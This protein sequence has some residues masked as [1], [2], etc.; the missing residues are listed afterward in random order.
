[1]TKLN[2]F[3][4]IY[5]C[6]FNVVEK[7]IKQAKNCVTK[8]EI[9]TLIQTEAFYDSALHLIPKIFSNEWPFLEQK[10]DNKFYSKENLILLIRPLTTLEKSWIKSILLDKRILLFISK[11]DV[12]ILNTLLEDVLPLFIPDDFYIF[13]KANDGDPFDNENYITNFKTILK[14]INEK[15]VLKVNYNNEEKVIF[16]YKITFSNRDDKF[17][18]LCILLKNNETYETLTLNL[19]RIILCEITNTILP[20]AF[21]VKSHIKNKL[22]NEPITLS[23][24]KKRSALERFMLQFASWEKET[25]YDEE[26][27]NYICKLY[28]EKDAETEILIRVLS[29]GPVIKVL[30]HDKFLAQVKERVLN[31]YNLNN[32]SN[33]NKTKTY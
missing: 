11:D 19:N 18:L 3:S 30:G 7:I 17:R 6:Y 10:E 8:N 23:I 29:F 24:S 14:A 12:T 2:I 31:Q 20:I 1:M 4:E 25:E 15:Q 13:D 5:G 28:Y 26:T 33:Q 32:N 21:N 16:P 27:E 22:H 9:E